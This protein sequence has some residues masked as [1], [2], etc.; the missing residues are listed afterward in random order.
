MKKIIKVVLIV[1][2]VILAL[3]IV[4]PFT[5]KDKIK[6]MV[7]MEASNMLDAKFDFD[8]LS[9]SLFRHFPNASIYVK[10]VSLVGNEP[11]A[12]DTLLAADEIGATV[13][14]LSLFGNEGFKVKEVLFNKPLVQGIVLE[15]GKANW[16]IMGASSD[17][18]EVAET[19][20]SALSFQL[21][22]LK[23]T[24]GEIRYHDRSM[25]TD[26]E[27]KALNMEVT[28]NFSDSRTAMK[29]LIDVAAITAKM[30]K[31]TYLN[32]V[33]FAADVDLDAD[34]DS[35]RFVFNK[36]SV[37]INAIQTAFEGW[38][39]MPDTTKMTM[40][41]KLNTSDVN[42]REILSLVPAIYTNEFDKLTAEGNVSLNAAVR[43]TLGQNV[44]PE[45]NM[46]LQVENGMFHYSHLPKKV[47]DIQIDAAVTSPGGPLDSVKASLN[48]FHFT[49]GNN[50]F[51]MTASATNMES[52]L[53]FAM[54]AI[55]KMNLAEVK[56]VYPLPDSISLDGL[57]TADLKIA[58]SMSQIDK[59]QYEQIKAE[60]KLQ[61]EQFDMK[62]GN[63]DPI[64]I[65][66]AVMFFTP[67]YVDLQQFEA[68]MGKND[69]QMKG[70]LEQFI[71]Y[72]LKDETLKGSLQ[73]TSNYINLNDFMTS[74]EVA[75]ADTTATVVTDSISTEMLLIPTNLDLTA[76]MN[77]KQVVMDKIELTD[78]QGKAQIKGGKAILNGLRF[79]AFGGTVGAAGVYDTSVPATPVC[80]MAFEVKN[81]SFAKTF[82]AVQSLQKVAPI[83]ENME[84]TYA[85][86]LAMR[87]GLLEGM[88]PDL[89]SLDASGTLQSTDVRIAGVT[90]LDQLAD[91]IKYPA[92]KNIAP[93]DLNLK[94][95]IREGKVKVDPFKINIGETSMTLG[96]ITGLDQSVDY[97]GTL[98]L[99]GNGVTVLGVNVKQ[100]PF[101]ITGTFKS[102]K[103]A[104]DTNSVK[105]SV[106]E[107][108]KETVK[109]TV[110][111]AAGGLLK[112]L[113]NK[114]QSAVENSKK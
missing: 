16:D 104:L 27:M 4:L 58:G 31:Q 44:Y 2:G 77:L 45:M 39:A 69:V 30:D 36:N 101:T 23:I 66:S 90:A 5:M 29:T 68:S 41:V 46:A 51:D 83:F 17:T 80:D 21:N 93:K 112:G 59:E 43:G 88:T 67:K 73:M 105:E 38:V 106:T 34:L 84:G 109:E 47:T 28:G 33:H 78:M 70:R 85:M 37:T 20:E 14:V 65:R 11:F 79:N 103:I 12:G 89:N 52:D 71:P 18:T 114:V 111:E 107:E 98:T 3:M 82:M 64:A 96:G 76:E 50:P 72:F 97:N 63:G 13:N 94:F 91:L 56:T 53:R 15:D 74:E 24:D 35:M 9:I 48:K 32:N 22:M 6:S 49:L 92:L 108:V 60:G 10:G 57:F 7:K 26:L 99:G 42:F 81:A 100:V 54:S 55:G 62:Q 8:D 95:A 19:E 87:C 40:D 1:I 102:P 86:S 25:D 61:L 75:P 113:K 110:K